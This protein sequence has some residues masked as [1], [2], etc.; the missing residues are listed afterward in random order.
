MEFVS[1]IR[2]LVGTH[3]DFLAVH[4]PHDEERVHYMNETICVER[5]VSASEVSTSDVTLGRQK[6]AMIKGKGP[7][8]C[9]NW[10]MHV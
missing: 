10:C 7:R 5:K 2:C 9:N 1:Q 4:R 6:R 8:L 3:Q